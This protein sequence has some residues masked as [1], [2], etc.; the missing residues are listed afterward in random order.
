MEST[1]AEDAETTQKRRIRSRRNR[2]SAGQRCEGGRGLKRQGE[3]ALEAAAAAVLA[4]AVETR[5][6]KTKQREKRLAV[7]QPHCCVR[8][9]AVA[10]PSFNAAALAGIHG[11]RGKV[12]DEA[13]SRQPSGTPSAVAAEGPHWSWRA[14]PE[15]PLEP[16]G[17]E[18]PDL[19]E[20]PE[21]PL[22]PLIERL[23]ESEEKGIEKDGKNTA[24]SR[25]P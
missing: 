16:L 9:C 23:R 25:K 17:P 10:A 11:V 5:A 6:T 20:R 22:G 24:T 8:L 4:W 2:T 18:D 12:R 7:K 1:C 19:L 3:L 21:R 13:W 14:Q 15:E